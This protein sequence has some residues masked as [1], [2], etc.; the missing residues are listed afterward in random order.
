MASRQPSVLAERLSRFAAQMGTLPANVGLMT[1]E[2][3]GDFTSGVP[4]SQPPQCKT[5][6]ERITGCICVTVDHIT[7][8]CI[9][10]DRPTKEQY[11]A[12]DLVLYYRHLRVPPPPGSYLYSDVSTGII[13]LLIGGSPAR[14]LDNTALTGWSRKVASWLTQPLA[15][16][17]TFLNPPSG[18]SAPG[19]AA[20]YDQALVTPEVSGG[21]IIGFDKPLNRGS[22]YLPAMPAAVTIVGGG[23][24]G[25]MAHAVLSCSGD[26]QKCKVASVQLDTPESGGSGYLPAPIATFGAGR[27]S[28]AQGDVVVADG[29]VVGILLHKRGCYTSPPPVKIIGGRQT[30]GRNATAEVV[31]WPQTMSPLH[32]R[33]VAFVRITDG[34]AGYVEPLAVRVAPGQPFLNNIPIWAPAGA[35]SS[36]AREMMRLVEAA[37]DHRVVNG[38]RIPRLILDGFR[39]AESD[40]AEGVTSCK[41]AVTEG[42]GLAWAILPLGNV[43]GEIIAKNGGINGFSTV[44]FVVPSIDLGIVVFMNSRSAKKTAELNGQPTSIATDTGENLIFAILHAMG[45]I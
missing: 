21:R 42:S 26:P 32:P 31:L 6:D 37:L 35:L 15:M 19:V 3:L 39:I 14:P 23:G 16:T 24:T 5:P 34:G 43:L 2:E 13:G 1:L 17:H 12:Q 4:D 7:G 20:G 11:D 29:K 36:T 18:Q 22:N 8:Q 27:A 9:E 28:D 25:A 33:E 40:Y 44:V 41:G 45:A 10:Q 38:E 30:G